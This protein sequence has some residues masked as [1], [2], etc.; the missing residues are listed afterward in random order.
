MDIIDKLNQLL[1]DRGVDESII[2]DASKAV[3]KEYGGSPSYVAMRNHRD[4]NIALEIYLETAD[5]KKAAIA[6]G[7]SRAHI[8]SLFK[9]Y[10][11]SKKWR[12]Q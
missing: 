9:K 7:Y 8:Y 2:N 4:K 5:T 3:R 6:S 10:R 1:L 12:T 11:D